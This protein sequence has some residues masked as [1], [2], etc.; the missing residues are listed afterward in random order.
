MK[1]MTSKERIA[2]ILAEEKVD[3]VPHFPFILGFCAKNLGYPISTIYS[4]AGK[5]FFAQLKTFEQ[6]GVDW[7][8]IYGYASYGTWEF[9]GEIEMPAGSYQQAPAHKM[10]PVKSEADI[11]GLALPDVK[12]AGCLP[13]AMAFSKLQEKQG[14]PISVVLGGNFTIAGNICAVEKLCRWMLKK[15]DTAHRALQLATEH[16]IDIVGHWVDTFGAERV[17]PQFWEPLSANLIISPR[18]FEQFVLPYLIET[19]EKILSMGVRHILYHICGDQNANLPLWSKV[20]MGEPGLCSFGEEIDIDKAI[21]TLGSKAVIIGNI[22][23]SLLL[24]GKPE[25]IYQ[26]CKATIEKGKQAP[27]GFMLS[28]GCEVSPET[29]GYHLYLMKKA[30]A[31]VG[32]YTN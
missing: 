14:T 24:T 6:Y 18:Q 12:T 27:R 22:D 10:F 17:I 11:D 32:S 4:D 9:G 13:I 7:G 2:A 16:V 29:P 3:R 5:S 21:E 20:P 8:P 19:A 1:K 30:L 23:P 26:R 25:Q 28:S 15:P 31:D